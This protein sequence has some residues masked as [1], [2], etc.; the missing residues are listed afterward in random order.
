VPDV[1][2]LEREDVDEG[3]GDLMLD[4]MLEDRLGVEVLY[5][6]DPENGHMCPE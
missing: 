5:V 6:P 1:R 4:R 3:E 2:E